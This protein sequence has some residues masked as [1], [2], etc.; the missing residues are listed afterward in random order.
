MLTGFQI[1][2]LG[3]LSRCL[4]LPSFA[5]LAVLVALTV[6]CAEKPPTPNFTEDEVD[7]LVR[8][9]VGKADSFE[10]GFWITSNNV[11]HKLV[12]GF[13]DN[14]PHMVTF[15]YSFKPNGLWL[16]EVNTMWE[17][18]RTNISSKH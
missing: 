7:Q 5:L 17:P 1:V 16:V 18:V 15:K 12:A 11:R 14:P 13:P 4:A 6:A 10:Q 8:Y 9:S 2:D 3:F